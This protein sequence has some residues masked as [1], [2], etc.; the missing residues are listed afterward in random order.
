M[1]PYESIFHLAFRCGS[2]AAAT[3]KMERFVKHSILDVA[4]ALDP[5]LAFIL[6]DPFHIFAH[7]YLYVVYTNCFYK[8]H[9][10]HYYKQC[11][12]LVKVC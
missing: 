10:Q 4:A 9:S 12:V 5:L 8:H 3:S 7:F 1:V 2:R 11:H 6:N